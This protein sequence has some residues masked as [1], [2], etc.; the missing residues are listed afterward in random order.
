MIQAGRLAEL[1]WPDFGDFRPPLADFYQFRQYALAWVKDGK[2]TAQA[3]VV[4]E[5]VLHADERGLEAED[6]DGRRWAD[7]IAALQ[8]LH[9]GPSASDLARFD[10]ALSVS[11]MRFVSDMHIGRLNPRYF[12][13]GFNISPA[14]YDLAQ[15][16]QQRIVDAQ[17]VNAALEMAEP[18]FPS[19]QQARRALAAYLRL[20]QEDGG[21]QLPVPEKPVR[22][23]E[24][25]PGVPRLARLLRLIGDLSPGPALPEGTTIYDGSLAEAVKHFQLRHGLDPDGRLGNAT[26]GQLNLPLNRRV[27]QLV[28]ALERWRWV[29]HEFSHPPIIVNIPEFQLRAWDEAGKVALTMRVVVGKAYRSETP[30]FAKEMR[31]VIFRPYWNVPASIQVKEMMPKIRKDRNYLVK[32]GFEVTNT[33]GEVVSEGE[34][35]AEIL[36]DLRGG[37]LSVRQKP[38]PK[39]SLGLAKF[40]FPNEYDVY[41]HGTP[42][43]ELF[44]RSRRDF[45]HGC[46]RVEDPVKLAAWVLQGKPAWTEDSIQEAMHGTE[47]L[48]VNLGDPIMVLVFYTTAVALADGRILFLQDIY[49]YDAA[50]ERVLAQGR[51]FPVL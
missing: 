49:G 23:G 24:A 16:L 19:Y 14:K 21:E 39:N 36:A 10:L 40:M 12:H 34:V 27:R 18:P 8:G 15:F 6:Y 13:S 30:V 2:P 44:S 31:Y 3:R 25:Y 17:D 50:M 4:I 41:L 51:P 32:N 46:I 48:Q 45:S 11:L 28:L 22:R 29:P 1:R 5:A 33:R 42:E 7:R 20:A 37:R 38:G 35:S 26:L 47:T 43:T 9:P